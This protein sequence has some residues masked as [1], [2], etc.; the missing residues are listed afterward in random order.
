M[1]SAAEHGGGGGGGGGD[2][3]GGGGGSSWKWPL[4]L[5]AV[6]RPSGPHLDLVLER[7]VP[8]LDAHGDD[9]EADDADRADASH[10]PEHG[11]VAL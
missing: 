2:G 6:P 10:V 11:T 8:V 5:A 1:F 7:A 4:I 9:H 3:G